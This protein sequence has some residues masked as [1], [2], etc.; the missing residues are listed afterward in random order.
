MI[1]EQGLCQALYILF[2]HHY[3]YMVNA[4][5]FSILVMTSY[6]S[7]IFTYQLLLIFHQNTRMIFS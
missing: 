5:S 4:I 6:K 7:H 3:G 2:A 1:G